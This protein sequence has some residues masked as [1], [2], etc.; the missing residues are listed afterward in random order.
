MKS[1]IIRSCAAAG[2]IFSMFSCAMAADNGSSS[3]APSSPSSVEFAQKLATGWNLGN[4]FDAGNKTGTMGLEAETSWGMPKTTQAMI[5]EVKNAGFSTIRIPVSWH[6]HVD[7]KYKIDEKWLNR[8]QEVVDW[9]LDSG[10]YVIINIHHDNLTE[11]EMRGG[12][13]GFCLSLDTSLQSK[14]ISYLTSVWKQVATKFK[15]YDSRLVFEIVNE[16]RR[17]GESNEWNL[18]GE[19]ES[20]LWNGI[21]TNYEQQCLNTIRATGA[22]NA[23]RFIMCPE[24]AASPHFLSYYSLPK[25][26]ASDKLILSTHAYDPYEFCMHLGKNNKFDA[27]VEGS[28]KYLFNMLAEK[29]TSKGIGVV[30]GET[31]ASDKKNTAD[32]VKWTKCY[33]SNAK[34][35][36]VSVILWDNNVTVAKGGDI[37]SGECHGYFDRVNL[38][39]YFP[40]INAAI[41]AS[42]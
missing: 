16:P 3:S 26:T 11:A 38:S 15:N 7:S 42:Y 31:S 18:N 32:R 24:Y 10:L 28:I 36:K 9:A 5:A 8:V 27:S 2:V 30:M 17:I 1:T 13:A 14:S 23:D 4:T 35:A 39:W 12:T 20:K 37:D 41:K 33:Y 34:A 19:Q 6:T 22:N 40:E 25:D 29:Y 21:I